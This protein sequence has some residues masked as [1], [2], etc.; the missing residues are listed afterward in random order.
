MTIHY[1]LLDLFAANVDLSNNIHET[2]KNWIFRFQELP[3]QEF[4]KYI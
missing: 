2:T 3:F 4:P 1:F